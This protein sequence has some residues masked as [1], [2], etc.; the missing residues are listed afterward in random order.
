MD[1]TGKGKWE[2]VGSD[3][4]GQLVIGVN[5][6]TNDALI[7]AVIECGDDSSPKLDEAKANAE[8]IVK[9]DKYFD[10]V[11]ERLKKYRRHHGHHG[12]C[13]AVH[14][15]AYDPRAVCDCGLVELLNNI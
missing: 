3:S 8:F 14:Y 15:A 9:A 7:I 1:R 5:D 6:G 10:E 2:I 11:V 12:D 13:R 4:E